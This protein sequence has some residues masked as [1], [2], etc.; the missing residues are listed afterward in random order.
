MVGD[1]ISFHVGFGMDGLT[2]AAMVLVAEP[3]LAVDPGVYILALRHP[4]PTARQLATMAELA[5]GRLTLGVGFGGQ[6]RHE[7]GICGVDP[8]TRGA[9]L[10]ECLHVLRDLGTGEKV[11]F[12]GA[13]IDLT[14]AQILPACRPPVP[15]IV[16][17]RSAAAGPRGWV[18]G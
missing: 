4:V 7:V 2:L 18:A 1:H 12:C 3:R 15:L 10:D 8:A 9:R 5:P 6:D 13:H 14:D 16:G 17:G 11:T